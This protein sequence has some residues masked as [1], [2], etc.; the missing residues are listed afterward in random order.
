MPTEAAFLWKTFIDNVN[1][2]IKVSFDCELDQLREIATQPGDKQ[3]LSYPQHAF[4]FAVYLH[5]LVTLSEQECVTAFYQSRFHLLSQYQKL[6]EHAL[7]KSEF[8]SKSDL[9]LIQATGI[10][11]GS[12]F[13]Q[14]SGSSFADVFCSRHVSTG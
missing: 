2:V 9:L 4:C 7:A 11:M 10:Y 1:P 8:F 13:Y 6:Y 14:L 3:N 5:S 12:I